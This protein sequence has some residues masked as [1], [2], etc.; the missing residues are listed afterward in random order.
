MKGMSADALSWE[1]LVKV[2]AGMLTES[3]DEAGTLGGFVVVSG[4]I[5]CLFL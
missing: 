1:G 5:L 4:L 3:R 2:E